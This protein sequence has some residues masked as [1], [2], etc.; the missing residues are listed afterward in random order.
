MSDAN[1]SAEKTEKATPQ[2]REKAR[3][4]GQVAMSQEVGVAATMFVL[5]AALLWIIP[6]LVPGYLKT[7]QE[8]FRFNGYQ[9]LGI[10]ETSNYVNRLLKEALGLSLPVAL[11]SAA[12]GAF[13]GFAQIGI[14]FNW[15]L[16]SFKWNR[17]NPENW[18][19]KVGSAELP[20]TLFKSMFKGI[21]L[22]AVALLGLTDLPGKVWRLAGANPAALAVQLQDIA[23]TVAVRVA[24]ALAIVAMLDV[25]WTRYR[26]EEKLKMSR[27]EVKDELKDTEGNPHVKGA[28]RRKMQE[29]SQKALKDKV[30]EATV[31]VTNPT[32]YAVALRYWRG[33]DVSPLVLVKG[34]DYKAARIKKIAAELG[35]MVV[36]NKP[37]ARS[38]YALVKEGQNV[39]IELYRSV[40]KLLAIVY[41]R[42]GNAGGPK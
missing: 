38:L 32:H 10:E 2:K 16:V 33:K 21:G 6:N 30:K 31:V 3:K 25:L 5:C 26:H 24:G 15:D 29:S 17:L 34:Q 22:V 8:L 19:K 1:S 4:E 39:P 35:I 27:Q 18:L 7:M 40:A 9:N 12:L 11:M 37:L 14:H 41:R 28:M 36:E 20:V 23:V 13:A 42:R